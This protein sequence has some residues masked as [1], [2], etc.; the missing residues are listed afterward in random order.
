MPP[1]PFF[2]FNDTA[3]TEIYTLSLHDALPIDP[4]GIE[5]RNPGDALCLSIPYVDRE[6]RLRVA[7]LSDAL[8]RHPPPR[9][10]DPPQVRQGRLQEATP[11]HQ[12]GE[13]VGH[14][15]ET[16]HA[17]PRQLVEHKGGQEEISREVDRRSA[18]RVHEELHEPVDKV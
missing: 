10:S 9:D 3:T 2:F 6:P 11:L 17:R 8:R 14:P 5:R 12:R 1:S 18:Q 7:D 16:G 13:V 4:S 15:R